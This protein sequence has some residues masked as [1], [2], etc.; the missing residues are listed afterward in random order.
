MI[1]F[2]RHIP[3]DSYPS[4]IVA[5][6]EPVIKG[7]LFRAQGDIKNVEVI[8]LREENSKA[9]EFHA[10][11]HIEPEVAALRVIK[12]MHGLYFR[13]RRITV[14]QYFLRNW[15]NDKRSEEREPIWQIKEKRT[16]PCRRRKL[17]MYKI[18]SPEYL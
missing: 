11:A 16:N 12:K 18:A 9:L 10:L 14:R 7:G 4:E 3:D 13:G 5:L 8:A 1:V 15:K 6:I 17:D 2:F